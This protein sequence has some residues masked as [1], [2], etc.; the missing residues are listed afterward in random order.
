MMDN[1]RRTHPATS[2]ALRNLVRIH[3][4]Q[5]AAVAL[6]LVAAAGAC[7]ADKTPTLPAALEPGSAASCS[8]RRPS[9]NFNRWQEDWNML[10]QPC[11]PR[12]PMDGLKYLPLS[13]DGV[14]YLSFGANLRER[15]EAN[16]APLFG[17]GSARSDTY[18]LQ[19]S[20]VHADLRVGPHVQVFTQIADS[21]AFH[22]D[23][24]SPV[25]KDQV[26]VEQAFVA[27]VGS[28]GD[29]V[30][31]LRAGRQQM[32][33]D[34]QRFVAVR[35]GPNVRQ[36]FDALWADWE[37]GD[38][39]LIAY[40]TEPVQ[41]R[42]VRNFDDVSN[43]RQR[44]NGIRVERRNLGPGSLSGYY[45]RYQR[46][47]AVFLDGAGNEKRDVYDL[48]YAGK[49]ARLDW[50]AELMLQRGNVGAKQVDAWAVGALA[51]F[52]FEDMPAQPRLGLQV[53]AASGDRHKG[54]NTIGTFNPL[55][56]N[57]A[58]FTL[59]GY[60]GYAN[61]V[62]VKPSI[63]IKPLP[64]LRLLAALGMQWR[65]TTADAV[66]G[67]GLAAVPG[68]AGQG[69]ARTGGYAQVRIDWTISRNV[70]ASVEGV[71]FQVAESIRQL[72]GRNSNYMGVELKFG[73]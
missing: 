48:R 36:S 9:I 22:K 58:Y 49:A 20:E 39:R 66:Y 68:S 60:S 70:T 16:N 55:F 23:S 47:G 7:A 59:A 52:T 34:L 28:F 10:A 62:H 67:Q 73:W 50:D 27:Y 3:I 44:F 8:V 69:G 40:A 19:R 43:S 63:T 46:D 45:S 35:D 53:D 4:N 15:W 13:E 12:Q 26:D 42:D 24:I 54:D 18:L 11:V 14:S 61:I 32:A 2:H 17:A 25:D 38:W 72:G 37:I 6:S 1:D 41:Y 21:R 57:G 29:S 64:D 65:A 71:R 51:G 33:F 31:K 30:V 56:P 5:A